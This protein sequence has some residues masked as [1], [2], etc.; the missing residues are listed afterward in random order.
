MCHVYLLYLSQ[1]N[2]MRLPA[3]CAAGCAV[4]H[5][6]PQSDDASV[7]GIAPP[8]PVLNVCSVHTTYITTPY[9]CV[10]VDLTLCDVLSMHNALDN[11]LDDVSFS[12]GTKRL[13][14][15]CILHGR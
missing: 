11:A 6:P 3:T 12:L 2:P 13:V 1:P 7:G 14:W 5:L 10:Q 15:Q 9:H 4:S 8:E